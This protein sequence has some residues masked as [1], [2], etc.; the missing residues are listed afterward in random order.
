MRYV[1]QAERM[2]YGNSNAGGSGINADSVSLIADAFKLMGYDPESIQVVKKTSAY[3][4]G[5]T[6]YSDAEWAEILQTEILAERPIVFCAVDGSGNG[7][8]AFNVDGYDGNNNKYHINFGWSGDGND[9]CS[10]NAF[11]YSY[12]NFDAYQQAVIGIQPPMQ[13]PGIKVNRHP[14]AHAGP[15]YQGE[16]LYLEYGGPCRAELYCHLQG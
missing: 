11:G 2:E 12:Y 7:G 16:P 8:H 1:G 4:G 10:L 6:L 9:W 14:A 13:G 15:W 5:E 3:E